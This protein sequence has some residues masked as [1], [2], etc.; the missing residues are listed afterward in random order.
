MKSPFKF[1]DSYTKDDSEIFFGREREIEEYD[2]KFY[3]NR[4]FLL[5]L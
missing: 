5:Y 1:L 4:I 3:Y 2:F